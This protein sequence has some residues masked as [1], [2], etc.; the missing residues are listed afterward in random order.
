MRTRLLSF[1]CLAALAVAFIAAPTEAVAQAATVPT[2]PT[3]EAPDIVADF[4][5][6]IAQDHPWLLAALAVV[7][8]LRTIFKPL[9]LAVEKF[10]ADSPDKDDD[11]K[12][13]AVERSFLFRAFAWFLDYSASVKLPPP[14]PKQ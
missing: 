6:G 12:L 13:E 9:R 4:I 10:V 11:A 5:G 14:K 3:V 7:G 1:V 2:A 8:F